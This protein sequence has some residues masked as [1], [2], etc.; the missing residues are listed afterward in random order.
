[1]SRLLLPSAALLFACAA[2]VQSQG[3]PMRA[4]YRSVPTAVVPPDPN[5]PVTGAVQALTSQPER[6]SI[7]AHLH[8]RR[9]QYHQFRTLLVP[10]SA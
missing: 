10:G 5:E 4:P 6:S 3:V 7:A 9:R 8:S 1:M 2:L